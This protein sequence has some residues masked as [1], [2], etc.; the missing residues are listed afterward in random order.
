MYK[1]DILSRLTFRHFF[2][3][4]ANYCYANIK[5]KKNTYKVYYQYLL[6]SKVK[7]V[8]CGIFKKLQI[9]A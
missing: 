2:Y 9:I 3:K 8:M 7:D 1:N 6:L 4:L 5:T